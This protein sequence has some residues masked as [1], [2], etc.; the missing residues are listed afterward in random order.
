MSLLSLPFYHTL[1]I[2]TGK[3]YL[4][5]VYPLLDEV[6]EG[7]VDSGTQDRQETAAE[8]DTGD[9]PMVPGEPAQAGEGAA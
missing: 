2:T 3:F 4:P 9:N 8:V 1:W 7:E 5:G 6:K